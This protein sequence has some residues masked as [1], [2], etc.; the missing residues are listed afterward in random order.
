MANFSWNGRERNRLLIN[1]GDGCFVEAAPA[2]GIDSLRDARGMAASDFDGDGDVDFIV[3]NY[4]ARAEYFVNQVA[5]AGGRADR[6]HWLQV[7][8]RGRRSNRDG[9]GAILRLESGGR[10][11]MRVVTA[12][13]GYISQYSRVAHFGL[14]EDRQADRLEVTWPSG[15]RQLFTGVE[16]DQLIEID[17]DAEAVRTVRRGRVLPLLS[18]PPAPGEVPAEDPE[19]VPTHPIVA[20]RSTA[21]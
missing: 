9:V 6:A 21:P 5:A 3:N 20:P 10:H 16:A 8:L 12:G 18:P 14:G 4:D 1:Q 7:V 15:E 19:A 2:H 11:Q 13:D 17:E